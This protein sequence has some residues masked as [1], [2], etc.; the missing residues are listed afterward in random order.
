MQITAGMQ[1]LVLIPKP[2]LVNDNQNNL[3]M[4]SLLL[5]LWLGA[6]QVSSNTC[7]W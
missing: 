6:V 1:I 7:K 2:A 4:F 3:L 5:D